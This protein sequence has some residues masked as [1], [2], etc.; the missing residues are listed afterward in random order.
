MVADFKAQ[1]S[2]GK[3]YVLSQ[4]LPPTERQLSGFVVCFQVGSD[5]RR[6]DAVADANSDVFFL[7]NIAVNPCVQR[8]GFGLTLIKHV[9]ALARDSGCSSIELYTNELM[10]ENIAWYKKLGFSE[11]DHVVEDGFSRVYMRLLVDN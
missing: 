4:G 6:V 3:I 9:I 5:K 11:F 8:S 10:T 2:D 1:I 7:E